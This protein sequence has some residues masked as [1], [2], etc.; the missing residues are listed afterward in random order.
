M[1]KWTPYLLFCWSLESK[2]DCIV[3]PLRQRDDDEEMSER[4]LV[5]TQMMAKD[6]IK[7]SQY[8]S[9]QLL[10]R[11]P[12]GSTKLFLLQNCMKSDGKTL[13]FFFLN[14]CLGFLQGIKSLNIHKRTRSSWPQVGG[15]WQ[16]S[17]FHM[18]Q[19]TEIFS[20]CLIYDFLKPL[21]I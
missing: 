18:K 9:Q 20:I 21:E 12:E 4:S 10:S 8:T 19:T 17:G 15:S 13:G 6:T 11:R 14:H 3:E 16:I 2:L 5:I 7:L 1:E